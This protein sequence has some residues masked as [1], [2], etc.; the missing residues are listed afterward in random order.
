MLDN[1]PIVYHIIIVIY[2]LLSH[3][4]TSYIAHFAGLY[5]ILCIKSK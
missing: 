3:I 4:Y 2:G 5:D 1:D